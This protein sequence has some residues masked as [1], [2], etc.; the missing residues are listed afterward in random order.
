MSSQTLF[1]LCLG[2]TKGVDVALIE[3]PECGK[4]VSDKAQKC[5]HCGHELNAPTVE[6]ETPEGKTCPECGGQLF[7]QN[8]EACP[9]CG[10]PIE[11]T[12]EEKQEKLA[13]AAKNRKKRLGIIIGAV[14]AVVV[15]G[16][17]IGVFANQ[18]S[19]TNKFNNYVDSYNKVVQN[20]LSGAA[21]AESVTNTAKRVWYSAINEKYKSGWDSDIQDYYSKDF[22][23]A[24]A[25]MYADASIKTKVSSIKTNQDLV[26]AEMQE[27]Q[28]APG[29]FSNSYSTINDMYDTYLK[30]TNLAISPS[31]S[32]QS[33][34]TEVNQLDSDF[35]A[36]LDKV[37][38]QIP[39]K[40]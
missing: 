18:A 11:L 19:N 40:K 14:I 1:S 15:I 16:V 25:S 17:I 28:G 20:M 36:A 5:I 3:C 34:S 13:K 32:Y 9:I 27:I 26:K 31:G 39:Q 12:E 24:L 8:A 33:F 38:T 2:T 7:D 29:E 35:I 10:C 22:N 30:F 4:N 23:T 6:E 21:D 37:K